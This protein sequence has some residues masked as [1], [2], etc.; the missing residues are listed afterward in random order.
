MVPVRD[1]AHHLVHLLVRLRPRIRII[2]PRQ[3]RHLFDQPLGEIRPRNRPGR[4]CKVVQPDQLV[5][6]HLGNRF[7]PIAHIDRPDAARHAV[8]ML[9][10]LG[11]P[12]LDALALD[13]DARVNRLKRF[14]L[15]QV[16]PD[17]GAVSLDHAAHVV[18]GIVHR[19]SSCIT[20]R[21]KGRMPPILPHHPP[22]VH[23]RLGPVAPGAWIQN[24]NPCPFNQN[25]AKITTERRG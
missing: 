7:A 19:E 22:V 18:G 20:N 14:V 13:N 24:A 23:P 9:A 3:P 16:V 10:A 17:M 5:I 12:D 15:D 1:L 6:D 11:V 8:D 25:A 21:A 2:H 4:A